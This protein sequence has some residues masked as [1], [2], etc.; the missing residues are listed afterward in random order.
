MLRKKKEPKARKSILET[1]QGTAAQKLVLFE[2]L[3]AAGGFADASAAELRKAIS[4]P[5]GERRR[6]WCTVPSAYWRRRA[7]TAPVCA[8]D[9]RVCPP[10]C[11]PDSPLNLA[12]ALNPE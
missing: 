9:A 3:K 1:M 11:G 12:P 4:V 5:L 2:K 7:R 8:A 10:R 6:G